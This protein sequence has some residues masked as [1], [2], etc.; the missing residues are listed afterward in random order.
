MLKKQ[1]YQLEYN[2]RCSTHILYEFIS[3]PNGLMEWFASEVL[4]NNNVFYFFWGEDEEKQ[5]ANIVSKEQDKFIRLRWSYMTK[6]EYFEFRIEKTDISNQT[7]LL[8]TD[9]ANKNEI[10]EQ[11]N[12]WDCQIKKL[13]HRIGN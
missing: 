13:L 1:L 12:L 8:I 10:K 9:F 7:I 6:D 3:T 4:L 11:T 5:K 2:V